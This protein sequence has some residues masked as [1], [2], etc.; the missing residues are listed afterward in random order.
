MKRPNAIALLALCFLALS[1]AHVASPRVNAAPGT[2]HPQAAKSAHD[3][4]KQMLGKYT[5]T[6]TLW[7]RPGVPAQK[8]DAAGEFTSVAGDQYFLM[9]YS[10]G[11]KGAEATN[12]SREGVFLLAGKDRT[13][14]ATWGDSFHMTPLPMQC[15]GE[16]NEQGTKLTFP[17]TYSAGDGPDW[18]WRTEFTIQGH[19]GITMEAYNI[20]PEGQE[21][22][23]V[24]AELKRVAAE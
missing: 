23:A 19:E 21:M 14:T 4:Y 5:G 17:G 16:L 22:L 18:H 15:E 13:A 7:L 20:T 24:R 10:W 1:G 2:P 11:P 12:G 8:S 6:Y 3:L 9:T